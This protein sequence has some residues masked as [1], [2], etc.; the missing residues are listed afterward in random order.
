MCHQIIE[1]EESKEALAK[2]VTELSALNADLHNQL[3]SLR[4]EL[5]VAN[6][7]LRIHSTRSQN[8]ALREHTNVATGIAEASPTQPTEVPQPSVASP[9][10]HPREPVYSSTAFLSTSRDGDLEFPY[11]ARQRIQATEAYAKD[12]HRQ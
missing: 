10:L 2:R 5:A 8:Q 7:E 9:Q 11:P 12:L 1:C 4:H 6:T 3:T